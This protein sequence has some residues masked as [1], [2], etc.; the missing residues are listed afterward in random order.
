[1]LVPSHVTRQMS[2][3]CLHRR[4]AKHILLIRALQATLAAC[5]GCFDWF[6]DSLQ[7]QVV[8]ENKLPKNWRVTDFHLI[9]ILRGL[10]FV[11]AYVMPISICIHSRDNLVVI[12]ILNAA[13]M[14]LTD[15]EDNVTF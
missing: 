11:V 14:L 1:M 7:A 9:I 5:I 8:A 4:T 2:V 13:V 10:I 3:L 12:H 15:E 6:V